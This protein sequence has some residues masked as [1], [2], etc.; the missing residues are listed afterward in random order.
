[1]S[2]TT[3]T[4][5]KKKKIDLFGRMNHREKRKYKG[6]GSIFVSLVERIPMTPMYLSS[7]DI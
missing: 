7:D 6:I 4:T 3:T 5:K 1:M 2:T